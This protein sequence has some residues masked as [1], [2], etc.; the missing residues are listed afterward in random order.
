MKYNKYS[1]QENAKSEMRMSIELG[2]RLVLHTINYVRI[3]FFR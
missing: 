2:D 1:V 3:W